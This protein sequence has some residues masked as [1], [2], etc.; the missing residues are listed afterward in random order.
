MTHLGNK[1]NGYVT[2]LDLR[3][4]EE[5]PKSVLAA[6]AVSFATAHHGDDQLGLAAQRLA[7]EWLALHEAGIV[8]QAPGKRARDLIRASFEGRA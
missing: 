7:R 1:L 2:A 4:Y 6:L 5:M 3:F 8:P